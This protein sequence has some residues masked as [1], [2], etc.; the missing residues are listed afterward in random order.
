M[1]H[2]A[3]LVIL[4]GWGI[5]DHSKSDVIYN[6]P[7]PY[8][9]GLLKKYPHSQLQA[10]GENVGLPD[11]QMGNSEVGHLNIGAGR[12]L[13]QDLVKINKAIKDGSIMA[14]PEIKR[15]YISWDLRQMA[16][17]THLWNICLLYAISQKNTDL[18]KYLS[19]VSWTAVIPTLEAEK[20]LSSRLPSIV[21][22][23]SA[24]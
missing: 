16:A 20:A 10:S 1:A 23:L 6:T 24:Q 4:D 19:T 11:G 22:S 21:Q 9:D 13:Y 15:L 14:N 2:K 7:T 18:K 3:L 8:W 12:V 17:S 5:G